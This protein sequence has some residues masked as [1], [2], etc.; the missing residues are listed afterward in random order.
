MSSTTVAE[1][2][3]IVTAPKQTVA[4]ASLYVGDLATSVTESQLFEVF[5]AVGPVVSVRVCR[6]VATRRSLGYAYVNYHNPV[7]A[8]RALDS[9]NF[10]DVQ[11]RQIRV[12]W[13]HRDPTLRKSGLGN[14][15]VKNLAPTIDNKTLYDTFSVFGNI[16]SCKVSMDDNN[17]SRG[18]GF[19]HFER[20]ED[21]LSAI[22]NVNGK[23]IADHVVTLEPFKPKADRSEFKSQFTNVFVKNLPGDYTQEKLDA[24]FSK[25]GTITSSAI[26]AVPALENK[27]PASFAFINFEKPEDAQA[28]ISALDGADVA[29]RTIFVARHKKRAEREREIRERQAQARMERQKKWAST[30]LYIKNL[31]EGFDDDKLREEFAPFGTIVSAKIMR[32]QS[33]NKSRGFGFVCFSSQEEAT[34]A[35]TEMSGK[36]VDEK[37]LYVALAQRKDIRH[38]QQAQRAA[39]SQRMG[40]GMYGGPAP[41]MYGAQPMFPNPLFFNPAMAQQAQQHRGLM[42]QMRGFPQGFVMAQPQAGGRGGYV[43]RGQG[44]G[45]RGAGRGGRGGRGGRVQQGTQVK[46]IENVRNQKVTS[47]QEQA[48]QQVVIDGATPLTLAAL[49]AAPEDQKKQMIGESLFPKVMA[50]E[51]EQA[52]KITGMLL[53]MD[54]GEVILLLESDAL[55]AEKVSEAKRVLL[56]FM[57]KEG[58]A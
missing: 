19:V 58:S 14:V 51:P 43:S 26:R 54:I 32:E 45:G 42:M 44:R 38:A 4:S 13:S 30:N 46:Y 24:L 39:A 20:H 5:N 28:A 23:T 40:F 12:M 21:A 50:L 41:Y 48:A 22:A 9:L 37:P 17:N 1:T 25:H 49:A 36:P 31:P 57:A 15:F 55:L 11:G 56:E 52:S 10:K 16:L 34:K 6:D 47:E 3:P 2:T 53:E 18:Y 7:D 8:E 33:T 35:L 29:G 27:E